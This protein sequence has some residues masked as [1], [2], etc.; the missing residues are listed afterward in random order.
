MRLRSNAIS[1]SLIQICFFCFIL[2]Y[3]TIL[4]TTCVSLLFIFISGI[5]S[6]FVI[7]VTTRVAES[8][9]LSRTQDIYTKGLILLVIVEIY[10]LLLT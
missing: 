7:P 10:D 2:T 8:V 6:N 9:I 1:F 3:L 5:V 4:N